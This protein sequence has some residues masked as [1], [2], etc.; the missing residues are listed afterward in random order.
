MLGIVSA[1][2]APGLALLIYVYLKD[3]H[4]TEPISYV[5]RTFIYGALLIFP[6]MFI[7]HVLEV[8]NLIHSE[9]AD[10]FISS[11][12]L[13]EFF[14]WLILFYAIYHHVKLR[15]PFDGIVYGASVSLGFATGENILYLI[16]N[17]VEHAL[18]RALLP[19]SSHAMFG[20]IM[21]YYFGTAEFTKQNKYK[22][23]IAAL[24][25]PFL[26]HGIYDYILLSQEFWLYIILPFMFFLWWFGL[27]KIKMAKMFSIA[28][29]N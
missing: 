24:I 26:L 20:V 1:G 5:I 12:L 2:I 17:G 10:A 11:S 27:S 7:Q 28:Q 19:V 29:L 25:I 9:L 3:E 8:E 18:T 14:K 15:E 22:A 16:G 13:E 23:V 4:Q 6:I 21:G